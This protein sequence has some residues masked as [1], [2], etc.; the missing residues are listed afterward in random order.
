MEVKINPRR[1]WLQV[2][3]WTMVWGCMPASPPL[4]GGTAPPGAADRPG[5]LPQPG[6]QTA[7]D[8]NQIIFISLTISQ[9]PAR[10]RRV[11]RMESLVKKPG[12]LKTRRLAP[13][14]AGP[15]LT[16]R[17][18]AGDRLLDSLHLEHPLFQ[19]PEIVNAQN[20]FTRQAI[21][22]EKAEFFLRFAQKGADTLIITEK[23]PGA[24][25][26]ELIRISL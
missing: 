9:D 26:Q 12:T 7:A 18:L 5:S 11:L 6:A 15:Y 3:L 13:A 10:T 19:Y 25:A 16:C 14:L 21:T 24:P 8:S 2:G 20:H 17:L 22:L 1:I 23:L 4:P